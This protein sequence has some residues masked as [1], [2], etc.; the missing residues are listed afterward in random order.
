MFR[1]ESPGRSFADHAQ[2]MVP[3]CCQPMG[4][5]RDAAK[6]NAPGGRGV[7]TAMKMIAVG[8]Y[9]ILKNAVMKPGKLLWL[10]DDLFGHVGLLS[11]ESV[12]A[13][14]QNYVQED[15]SRMRR[16]A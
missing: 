5:V 12:Q 1:Q 6:V 11:G 2:G 7:P 3:S 13:G 15:L 10:D 4:E 14:D 8:G 9:T 16:S